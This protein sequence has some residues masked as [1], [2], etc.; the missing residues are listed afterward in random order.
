MSDVDIVIQVATA[1]VQ[2]VIGLSNAMLQLNRAVSGAFNPMRNLDARARALSQAIGSTDGSLKNHAKSVGELTRNN[3]ILS[4]EL[5]RTKAVLK[6][7]GTEYKFATGTSNEFKTAAIKDLKAYQQ[8]LK[9]VR[10]RALTEDL[11]SLSQ[12][13]KRLGKDAQFVGRSLIIGLTTPIM[14]F[15]RYGL[16]ALVGVDREF[17]RLNKVLESVAP[18]LD[19]AAKKMGVDLSQATAQQNKQLQSMVDNYEKLDRKLTATS[20]KFGLSKNITVGLAGE[21]AELGIQSTDAI[22]KITELTAATEKIGNMD[23]GSSKDLVQALYFQ[24]QRAL[25]Q[26]GEGSKMS[27]LERENR[28]IEAATA[29]LRLFNSVENVTALTLRDLGD[30]FPEV[31]AAATSF[32][33]SMTEAGALLAPMK[34]AGFEVGA[35][36]NSIK[37]SLQRIVAPTKQN[38][39]LL[40]ALE[41]QYNVSFTGIKGTGLDAIQLLVDGF[42]ELKK[43]TAGQEGAMEFFAKLFGVRQGPRMEVAI[44]QMAEFDAILKSDVIPS[45]TSAE[46]KLQEFANTAIAAGN[47]SAGTNIPLVRSFKDIGIIARIASSNIAEG[48]KKTIEGFGVVGRKEVLE[49]RKVRDA[50]S[51]EI[52]K[53]QREGGE[54]LIGQVSSEAGRAM[55]VQLAGGANAAEV[56]QRE[57]KASLG[58]LDVQISILRNN[59]KMFAADLI[60][61]MKPAIE[62]I[63]EV[64]TRL[65]NAWKEL[66]PQTRRLITTLVLGF[67]AVTAAIGPLIFV[68]GQFRLAVGSI[69]KVI[70]GF[71]PGLKTMT[72]EMLASR[73]AM[74]NLK[75][76]LTSIGDTVYNTNGKFA[77]F[78]ATIASGDGPLANF[79]KKIGKTT[80]ILK[81]STTAQMS[82][83][84]SLLRYN[85]EQTAA[86]AGAVPGV[87]TISRTPIEPLRR[88]KRTAGGIVDALDPTARVSRAA[89]KAFAE[90]EFSM[91]QAGLR[92][93][94][95][96]GSRFNIRE[97]SGLLRNRTVG[98]R[99]ISAEDVGSA[100][101]LRQQ[102]FEDS[103]ITRTSP[104]GSLGGGI[105][106]RRGREISEERALTIARGGVKGRIV[107]SLD[108]I[109]AGA[110]AA[111]SAVTG[112][113]TGAPAAAT[114][115]YRAALDGAKNAQKA[116][117]IETLAFTGEGP[118]QFARM[119]AGV[120]GFAK[121]FG[122]VNNAIKL[123]KLT[124]I[125]SG[126][127]VIILSVGVAVML[128]MKNMDKFKQ[129]GA[130]GLKVVKESF[131]IVKNAAM[132]II[133]PI[134]DLFGSFGDGSQGAEGAVSGIGNAFNALAGVLK[135]VANMFS[136]LV[137]TIIQ[138]YMYVIVNIVKFVI[139]L[140]TG[141]WMDALK[142]LGAAF[143][144]AFALIGKIILNIMAFI[145]KQVINLIFELPSAFMK[146]W[147]WGVEKATDLFIGF[148]E[149]IIGQVKKIPVLGKFLGA[150]GNASLSVLKT[151]RNAY[152]GTIK[153]VAG[154]VNTA[155]DFLKRG[156]D[157]GVQN[158]TNAMDKLGKGG[159][160]Q[161]KGKI[162]IGGKGKGD[163]A[164][165]DAEPLQEEIANATGEGLAEGADEGGKALANKMKGYLSDLKKEVQ[166]DIADRIKTTIDNVVTA[167]KEGLK[168]Q[169]EA[170]LKIYDDQLKKIDETAKAEEK[171]TKTKEYENKK[172]ELEEQRALNRLNNQRNYN[173]AVYEGRIDD[174]RQ[175]AMDGQKNEQDDSDK[176]KDLETSRSKELADQR[177]EDLISSIKDARESSSKYFDEMIETFTNAAK[178]ITEF[179][180]TT[181]E[182]FNEQLE[183]LKTAANTGANAIGTSFEEGFTGV[184]GNLGVNATGPLTSALQTI[185]DTIV[186]NNPFGETGV[187]QKT[188][189][190]SLDGLK[191]K[192]E[193]MTDTLNMVIDENS[194]KFKALFEVYKSYK[195]LVDTEAAG[196]AGV[197][198][199][200]ITG[201]SGSGKGK[202]TGG[203]TGGGTKNEEIDLGK[204]LKYKD[205][206]LDKKYGG[207]AITRQILGSITGTVGTV[208]SSG[209]LLGSYSSGEKD[210]AG[211]INAS[212]YKNA[213]RTDARAIYDNVMKNKTFFL[214]GSTGLPYGKNLSNIPA[215]EIGGIMP[216]SQGGATTGPVQQGIPAILHG[217]EYV[218][219]NSAVKKYGW[220]MMD[221]INRGAYKPKPFANGG[222]I[223]L[224]NKT[225]EEP[226]YDTTDPSYK[227]W[228]WQ[229]QSGG[230]N[231]DFLYAIAKKESA[232]KKLTKGLPNWADIGGMRKSPDEK[233]PQDKSSGGFNMPISL[234]NSLG[235]DAFAKTPGLASV[236]QQMVINNRHLIF[237]WQNPKTKTYNTP[238]GTD[239]HTMPRYARGKAKTSY[240]TNPEFFDPSKSY[241]E[242]L[243]TN[244]NRKEKQQ[245][246][247]LAMGFATPEGKKDFLKYWDR[248]Q[249]VEGT[250]R[251]ARV[252]N[253]FSKPVWIRPRTG[254]IENSALRVSNA[255]IVPTPKGFKIGGLVGGGAGKSISD[256]KKKKQSGFW[257]VMDKIQ[258]GVDSSMNFAA[259]FLDYSGKQIKAM[260]YDPLMRVQEAAF[261]PLMQILRVPGSKNL[262]VATPAEAAYSGFEMGL[263]AFGGP[264]TE[265][266]MSKL[267]TIGIKGGMGPIE[268]LVAGAS[269]KATSMTSGFGI[270]EAFAGTRD[271]K[272]AAIA[273]SKAMENKIRFNVDKSRLARESAIL[274]DTGFADE[275]L[276]PPKGG[277]RRPKLGGGRK[278]YNAM[279]PT[280][281]EIASIRNSMRLKNI[282]ELDTSWNPYGSAPLYNGT[283]VSFE[284]ANLNRLKFKLD[285]MNMIN[286]FAEVPADAE[287]IS[288]TVRGNIFKSV[289][290]RMASRYGYPVSSDMQRD[291]SKMA[292]RGTMIDSRF[293]PRNSGPSEAAEALEDFSHFEKIKLVYPESFKDFNKSYDFFTP[294]VKMREERIAAIRAA[295]EAADAQ[296]LIAENVKKNIGANRLARFARERAQLK[297]ENMDKSKIMANI[298][299]TSSMV[300]GINLE[301]LAKKK[302]IIALDNGA[303]GFDRSVGVDTFRAVESYPGFGLDALEKTF[304][305]SGSIDTLKFFK[306]PSPYD[307]Q[308][309]LS[310][311]YMEASNSITGQMD[312]IKSLFALYE[313]VL[314]PRGVKLIDP[315][316]TSKYSRN[317]IKRLQEM[318]QFVDP[319]IAFI[320]SYNG[321]PYDMTASLN[322]I[323]FSFGKK[324]TRVG[325]GGTK[326]IDELMEYMLADRTDA[327][328]NLVDRFEIENSIR[329]A[330]KMSKRKFNG[331]MM[332][333]AQ[334]GPT[335]GPAQQGI[336]AM[337]HGGE[338]VVRNSAV[339][340]YGW[341]MMDQINR[342]SYQ[343]KEYKIGGLV[344]DGFGNKPKNE[345][346][347]GLFSKIGGAV[348]DNVKVFTST[349][350]SG[351]SAPGEFLVNLAMNSLGAVGVGKRQSGDGLVLDLFTRSLKET[352]LFQRGV[353]T[354]KMLTT[355]E[356][357]RKLMGLD[358]GWK[359][360]GG[361]LPM[362]SGADAFEEQAKNRN[363]LGE[364]TTLTPGG[365]LAYFGLNKVAGGITKKISGEQAGWTKE[366]SKA[367]MG[368]QIAGDILADTLASPGG[369]KSIG[370]LGKTLINPKK[371]LFQKFPNLQENLGDFRRSNLT[372]FF[373]KNVYQKWP[374]SFDIQ[375]ELADVYLPK[376]AAETG[377]TRLQ[378]NF[379]LQSQYNSRGRN[380]L[381]PRPPGQPLRTMPPM[382][383]DFVGRDLYGFDL[384]YQKPFNSIF[385]EAGANKFIRQSEGATKEIYPT[386]PRILS[387]KLT[388]G[389]R[390]QDWLKN[391][392]FNSGA[393]KAQ[394]I[395][396]LRQII[397]SIQR[398]EPIIR[399]GYTTPKN[400][401]DSISLFKQQIANKLK[402]MV[403][404]ERTFEGFGTT[405]PP[406]PLVV[407]A[408]ARARALKIQQAQA[409]R[410]KVLGN[411]EISKTGRTGGLLSYEKELKLEELKALGIDARDIHSLRSYPAPQLLKM[412]KGLKPKELQ[413]IVNTE[414]AIT[415][416]GDALNDAAGYGMHNLTVWRRG[417]AF[418]AGSN[419]AQSTAQFSFAIRSAIDELNPANGA[420][421][422]LV[423]QSMSSMQGLGQVDIYKLL[424]YMM[425]EFIVK[426]N[427]KQ[428]KNGSYSAH[429]Y[430]MSHMFG[431]VMKEL[432]PQT[433]VITPSLREWQPNN[434]DFGTMNTMS[435]RSPDG[436]D[437]FLTPGGSADNMT[438]LVTGLGDKIKS[439][440]VV[441]SLIETRKKLQEKGMIFP[442]A[443]Q[444]ADMRYQ[445]NLSESYFNINPFSMPRRDPYGPP[446]PA[447]LRLSPLPLDE[448]FNGGLIPG[449]ANGGAVP[450]FGSAG[451][452]ALLHGGEYVVNSK[453]V[454]NI[455]FAALEA[456]N[457]MRFNTPK[458]PSYAGPVQPQTSST[459]NVNIYVD[460]FIGEKQW[461]ES[462]M[463]DYNINVSP[464]NQ[465][466][467][468]LQNRTISTYNGINRGM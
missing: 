170:S 238:R 28:A 277:F 263:T 38:S 176:I 224:G 265:G 9:G 379:L 99:S 157:K 117:R 253:P 368:T 226:F 17:I 71:L 456:M 201:A 202:P 291:F 420:V 280:I 35:S 20:T 138:P 307:G 371:A 284:M 221:Q 91:E 235:G 432:R 223:P 425:D 426:Y 12:E 198:G 286:G 68:F 434:I 215:F 175:I 360:L 428:V 217:G 389:V 97:Q 51:E 21:F 26:S 373:P 133:R 78:I 383:A 298:K 419:S 227:E 190:A 463:K 120:A 30:A 106:K 330:I 249:N 372:P 121:S 3:T 276:A 128:V 164:E 410:E 408:E 64:S 357:P 178:K 364:G 442:N 98:F 113:I 443:K 344:K 316:S 141:K 209:L 135:F 381:P 243:V 309:F 47:K 137:K 315:G 144:G 44:A 295:R 131:D 448:M 437:S 126:I 445:Y 210:F 325:A 422:T 240:V 414:Y 312:A 153:T 359:G 40:K 385:E 80:G 225:K 69:G 261:N 247:D 418:G 4:S 377:R 114:A 462:M 94:G 394:E 53:A 218:V 281:D 18:N 323:D 260:T 258:G 406:N 384:Q 15:G 230:L 8:A 184:L 335:F 369:A 393:D 266:L 174:A 169:K 36:A 340:K 269:G 275:W 301:S 328:G 205:E 446:S 136:W 299:Q 25:Q 365:L 304:W 148:V 358:R 179:P 77:T 208:V 103:G 154:A 186:A 310:I 343:P 297:I 354:K 271:A 45:T 19:A 180:P 207:D 314:K 246:N 353:A 256:P 193:G 264:A 84:R 374:T 397:N 322:D 234:W 200:S 440:Q 123:T 116:L 181:A 159:V 452:P 421:K 125:A 90:E 300:G 56:A 6:G 61:K 293:R 81:E 305:M 342:G 333:Y 173:L 464:Q 7:L 48:Q 151:A 115:K 62:K 232:K 41:K 73:S 317:L 67:A 66:T 460:N 366:G 86:V 457:N 49:A 402:N 167:L 182:K 236:L 72:V 229:Q 59:F 177:R 39:E 287:L 63:S 162:S 110:S 352:S 252:Q 455:G 447:P 413:K 55:F 398:Q 27:F 272:I 197:A 356:D 185:T 101:N 194:S 382:P 244:E 206:Y 399:R 303:P 14:L 415:N 308:E 105:L 231:Y 166:S 349:L 216:Y 459:S 214:K 273:K 248:A 24:A 468:G 339:E 160:K 336:P 183:L 341:G 313:K 409:L 108:N 439:K 302:L 122:L 129:A 119:R 156:I 285:K 386:L 127:G 306:N 196:G 338:Y 100:I 461:F 436:L 438:N 219:R 88:L 107:E 370:N 267:A 46:K 140:F 458:S 290:A 74:L 321:M 5:N 168:S 124:L 85:R 320:D 444:V 348:L 453:A 363:I 326:N 405:M 2:N 401:R 289:D 259:G 93:G 239:A 13:Q 380:F 163:T 375:G 33:L 95:A 145:V 361:F 296:K 376:I 118:T 400:T 16:Q 211:S 150:A 60:V 23:I 412:L 11:K 395:S 220:G 132:E 92:R 143:G 282:K 228:Q 130:S 318:M 283:P 257:N 31:A 142:S 449:F 54:D 111:R 83:T 79:A 288:S 195:L 254:K 332:P 268:R 327:Y 233:N 423:I 65:Y 388:G 350:I 411:I 334:G 58:S 50:L 204:V 387:R 250:Q 433:A 331:G 171:L 43:S 324:I 165:V 96:T 294:F 146:A 435:F 37:V 451:F 82:V 10:V 70:F 319:D 57:L 212:R 147:A 274:R 104:A 245:P 337:L 158:A 139:S 431:E 155:G 241:N 292:T 75:N 1:G 255:K 351:I 430:A 362:Q 199:G 112:A 416:T 29:Q 222:K 242:N 189:D 152:V 391:T 467:A 34:A 191:A 109:G 237:G 278:G 213:I 378:N 345:K 396:E 427:I 203:S 270:N 42:N 76:P 454:K 403:V 251:I 429:S 392:L 407:A 390:M 417:E 311:G 465:K 404:P 161:S 149:F 346:K 89:R 355:G 347:K 188:I 424:G 52:L 87:G 172:R 32:G 466:T 262:K 187:W 192:Y 279:Q 22:A 329:Q 450:G 134:M 367:Y 102:A 441:N